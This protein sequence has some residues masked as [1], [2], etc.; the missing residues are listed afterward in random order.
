MGHT[1]LVADGA[2]ATPRLEDDLQELLTALEGALGPGGLVTGDRVRERL[3][4]WG[5]NTPC[6]AAAVARPASTDQVSRTLRLCHAAGRPVVAQGGLTGLVEGGITGPG[7]LALS[8][9]RMTEIESVD[10][11]NRTMTVQAGAPLEKVQQAAAEAGLLY[12]VDLGARG[13]ATIGGTI[14]TN[15]GGVRVIRYGMT[16]DNVLGLEAVLADGTVVSSM[17]RVLKNNTGYDLKQLFIG[18]EGTLGVVTR[19]VL[20]LRSQPAS[21]N[22]ALLAVDEFSQVPRLLARLDEEL[23]GTLGAF[24]VMWNEFYRLVTTPPAKSSAPLSQDHPLYVLVDALGGDPDRDSERFQEVLAACL[25]RGEATDAVIAQSQRESRALWAIREDV[26]Q[27]WRF[28]PFFNFDVSVALHHMEPYV[29]G[30]RKA[31]TT[32]WPEHR[33]FVFGH[34]GDGNLH[35][36]IYT[37]NEADRPAVE[38]CVYEPL[39]TIGGAISAEHGIGLEKRAHLKLSRSLEEIGLMRSLKRALDPGAILN[40]G[41]IFTSESE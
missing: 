23:A 18:S 4:G 22:T 5:R 15:A 16:R 14:S 35:I 38:R 29:A 39:G 28:A 37:G 40:P 10:I 32:R 30:L 8:L 33:R 31:L 12:P 17:N 34:A 26:E 1:Q 19:A 9:E 27:L 21:Q 41:K 7:E 11:A 6:E 3:S 13:S 36:A 20:R 2:R 25:E 24:E